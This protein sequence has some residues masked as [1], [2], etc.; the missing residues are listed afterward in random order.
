[1]QNQDTQFFM[2]AKITDHFQSKGTGLN[3]ENVTL[4]LEEA[5]RW[6]ISPCC[7]FLTN[8]NTVRR[9][10]VDRGKKRSVQETLR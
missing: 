8:T 2:L 4:V 6:Q 10:S 9:V 1:M 7:V 3:P 5:S